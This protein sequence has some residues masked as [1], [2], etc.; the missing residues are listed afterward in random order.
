MK[1]NCYNCAFFTKEDCTCYE[2]IHGYRE[3]LLELRNLEGCT[4][5]VM[6]INFESDVSD[7]E[8]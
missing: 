8:D 7:Q 3:V 4:N 2:P 1:K 6:N 5:W